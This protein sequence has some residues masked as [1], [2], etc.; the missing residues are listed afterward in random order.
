MAWAT[1][2]VFVTGE[3]VTAAKMNIVRGNILE[4]SAAT[5]TTAGD[6]AYADAA[7]SMGS[8]LGIGA[9]NTVMA[10]TGS[11][12]VWRT[13]GFA[14]DTSS[15]MTTSST[16]YIDLASW[17]S[18]ASVADTITTGTRAI[19]IATARV[20]NDTGGNSVY[21]SYAVS[22]ASTVAASDVRAGRYES[23]NA[24]DWANVMLLDRVTLTAGSNTFTLYAKVDGGTGTINKV[25]MVVIPF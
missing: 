4:S 5:V 7:N 25:E 8:R 12:P 24:D 21:L 14:Q 1:L 22:G 9:A 20:S 19:L 15:T 17:T 6:I 10:S 18:G 2:A 3:V 16:S 13:V 11:A 23:S